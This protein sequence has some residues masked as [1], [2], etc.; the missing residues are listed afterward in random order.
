[1][2]VIQ[3]DEDIILESRNVKY[4]TRHAAVTNRS[5]LF[6]GAVGY[7]V[8]SWLVQAIHCDLE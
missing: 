5:L 1:M 4:V 7:G 3:G 6:L 8:L 2:Y